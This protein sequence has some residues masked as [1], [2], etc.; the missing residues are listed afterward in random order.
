MAKPRFQRVIV[1]S[2]AAF[3]IEPD[4]IHITRNRPLTVSVQMI[5][6]RISD[7]AG[8]DPAIVEF[9]RLNGIKRLHS[10]RVAE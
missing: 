2:T 3:R 5:P 1:G 8:T 4:N 10:E 6:N 9:E 7:Q